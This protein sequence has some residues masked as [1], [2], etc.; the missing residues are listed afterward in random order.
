MCVG[1]FKGLDLQGGSTAFVAM[2]RKRA[3]RHWKSSQPDV[4]EA[5]RKLQTQEKK[6]KAD[7]YRKYGRILADKGFVF[8]PELLSAYGARQLTLKLE[9]GARTSMRAHEIP[10]ILS[11][12][13]ML[14]V[15]KADRDTY[16]ELRGLRNTIAHGGA[17]SLTVHQAVKKTTFVRQWATRID[18]H[19]GEHFMLLAKHVF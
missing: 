1:P 7:K 10:D 3:T 17:P 18:H 2:A 8:P 13:L 5:K 16:K 6:G 11:D 9:T 4:I 15:T 19:I 12:A 14:D